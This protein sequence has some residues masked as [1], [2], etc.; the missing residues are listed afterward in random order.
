MTDTNAGEDGS[1]ISEGV[2]CSCC[3]K[4]ADEGCTT[5]ATCR[6]AGFC[7]NH[8]TCKVHCP[9]SSGAIVDGAATRTVR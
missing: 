1:T 7:S 5:C 2:K 3:G 4:S 9:P 6:D 8:N